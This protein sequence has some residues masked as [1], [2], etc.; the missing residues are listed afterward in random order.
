M[1]DNKRQARIAGLLYLLV[2]ITAPLGVMIVPA[3]H[4][5]QPDGRGDRHQQVQQAG[6]PGLAPVVVHRAALQR[7]PCLRT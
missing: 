7:S 5:H 1:N 3:R 2:A 4:H 6:D